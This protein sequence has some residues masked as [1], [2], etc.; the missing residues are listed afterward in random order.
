M[1]NENEAGTE[2][3]FPTYVYDALKVKKRFEHMRVS[4]SFVSSSSRF[5]FSFPSFSPMLSRTHHTSVQG[6]HQEDAE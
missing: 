3:F 5:F 4:S 2:S 1:R 6:G